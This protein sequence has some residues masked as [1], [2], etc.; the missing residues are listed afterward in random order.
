MQL[1]ILAGIGLFIHWHNPNKF[2]VVGW[3][4]EDPRRYFAVG[5]FALLAFNVFELLFN[6]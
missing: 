1:L 2:D 5:L 6:L 3:F 4:H